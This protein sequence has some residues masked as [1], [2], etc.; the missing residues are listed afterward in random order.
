MLNI[1]VTNKLTHED[2]VANTSIPP[3]ILSKKHIFSIVF[4]F[5]T[6]GVLVI[7]MPST[8]QHF[9]NT[10]PSITQGTRDYLASE[11]DANSSDLQSD[12]NTA[13]ENYEEYDIPN[14]LFNQED[15]NS[16]LAQ[17]T[18]ASGDL[19]DNNEDDDG[20]DLDIG[21]ED[22][23]FG[24]D[25]SNGPIL[26]GT[27]IEDTWADGT[28]EALPSDAQ[29]SESMASQ[30]TSVNGGSY[31]SGTGSTSSNTMLAQNTTNAKES[32]ASIAGSSSE[33]S[34]SSSTAG[35]TT[36][37][38]VSTTGS[39]TDSSGSST[40]KD[41]SSALVANTG[42]S[43]TDSSTSAKDSST[44][45]STTG[46]TTPSSGS[47]LATNE[48]KGQSSSSTKESS[49]LTASSSSTESGSSSATS[50]EQTLGSSS[51][52]TLAQAGTGT[53]T[54]SDAGGNAASG[55]TAASGTDSAAGETTVAQRPE[56]VWYRN[57]V[58]SG[59]N[60]SNIFSR[61]GL[62]YA[63]LNRLTKV[64]S[65]RDLRLRVGEQIDFLIDNDNVVLEMV[66]TI[67]KEEQVRFTRLTATDDFTVVH[68][69]VGEHA[70]SEIL[71]KITDA[72]QMPQAIVLAK[73][74][75]DKAAALAK[76][77]AEREERDRI[78]N[79]NP[80]RPRLVM[81][82]IN[83]GENFA[84]AGRRAGLTPGD[85]KE[86]ERIFKG[87]INFKKLTVGDKFRVLFSG[88]GTSAKISAIKIEATQGVYETFIN[89]DDSNYYGE[90]EFTP[91]A[92]IFRRFPLAGDI[93]VNSNFNPHRRHPVTKRISPH[94]GIDFKATVGT[95]VYAPAD[96]TVSFSG[97]QRAAGYYI[98]INH[99]NNFST[100]YMHLSKSEVKKGQ[101]VIVGQMIART[102]NTGRTT[103]PHLHYEIRVNNKPMNPLKVKLP[104]SDHPNL[105]REQREAFANN[106]KLLRSELQNDRLASTKK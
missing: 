53:A 86:F 31:T 27:T 58:M 68:E 16:K 78:N 25:L 99:A 10:A 96:G 13:Q 67:D 95:P 45:N 5:V 22:D 8:W 101:K 41:G 91:T 26:S 90:N 64:A 6:C 97:Y 28:K 65:N 75:A 81:A 88:I 59:D 77:K 61:L 36:S 11:Q 7:P 72:S 43:G 12:E 79:T 39:P 74:R 87:K 9:D 34:T 73:E 44:S 47:M 94:N 69:K 60:F 62:P 76:A 52:Q 89:P 40:N 38:K 29:D 54:T 18:T 21:E 98:V 14:E 70:P 66:K 4:T 30:E 24:G 71:A 83:K 19:S 85:L 84:K 3:Y 56:G 23:I 82:T 104:S 35:T 2:Y 1:K 17:N 37:S 50:K 55:S 46:G 93:K 105:A 100:V 49:S 103:G 80:N 48:G 51:E 92:G 20:S 42:T 106:V 15:A 57:Q 32:G 33:N 63:T 102:G